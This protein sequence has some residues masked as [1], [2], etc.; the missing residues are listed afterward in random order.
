MGGGGSPYTRVWGGG[1]GGDCGVVGGG[2]NFTSRKSSW[3][4]EEWNNGFNPYQSEER[5]KNAASNCTINF[6]NLCI[7]KGKLVMTVI[8]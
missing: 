5:T 7:V 3:S 8:W 4:S 1:M 6:L 2:E